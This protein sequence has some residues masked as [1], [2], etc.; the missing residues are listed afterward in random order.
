MSVKGWVFMG[1]EGDKIEQ[2]FVLTDPK[3]CTLFFLGYSAIYTYYVAW[4]SI[5]R[6]RMDRR[7]SNLANCTVQQDKKKGGPVGSLWQP[8]DRKIKEAFIK[9]IMVTKWVYY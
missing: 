4:L 3:I 6:E 7:Y 9:D 2:N 1:Q 8:S 5:C